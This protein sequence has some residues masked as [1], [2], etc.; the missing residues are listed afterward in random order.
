MNNNNNSI[1][2]GTLAK[3]GRASISFAQ[4]NTHISSLLPHERLALTRE[5]RVRDL[6]EKRSA[7]WAR[8]REDSSKKLHRPPS[9]SVVASSDDFRA[10]QEDLTVV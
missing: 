10:K 7:E 4:E 2:F 6:F 5:S 9:Q 3:N 1:N 8:F